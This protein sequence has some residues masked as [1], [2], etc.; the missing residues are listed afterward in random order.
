MSSPSVPNT[1]DVDSL[2]ITLLQS[3]DS[4]LGPKAGPASYLT[5][6][7][8]NVNSPAL[9]GLLITVSSGCSL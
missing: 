3:V 8:Y 7:T 5:P 6:S 2:V 4:A 9:G 1:V